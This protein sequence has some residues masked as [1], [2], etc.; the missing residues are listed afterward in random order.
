MKRS[1]VF[2]II[3]LILLL[4]FSYVLFVGWISELKGSPNA[5]DESSNAKPVNFTDENILYELP[6]EFS[7]SETRGE[8]VVYSS[9]KQAI[10]VSRVKVEYNE[11]FYYSR[12]YLPS[13]RGQYR[14]R[15]LKFVRE[16]ENTSYGGKEFFQ[17]YGFGSRNGY[18]FN[19]SI[20]LAYENKTQYTFMHGRLEGEE[21]GYES[22]IDS[23]KNI[24]W[25]RDSH[26]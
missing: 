23:L 19:Y 8:T 2:L 10:M 3:V 21:T 4:F 17:S 11:S 15:G 6:E 7:Y 9:N 22:F 20:V 14:S 12:D 13:M 26:S 18:E 25:K 16:F 5:Y 24:K 1:S